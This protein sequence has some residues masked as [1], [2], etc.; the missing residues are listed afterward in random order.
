MNVKFVSFGVLLFFLSG[1]IFSAAGCIEK[2]LMEYPFESNGTITL[3]STYVVV[4][5]GQNVCY[6]NSDKISC[7]EPGEPFY[8]QDAQYYGTQPSYQDNDDGTITDLN[9]GLMWQ[10]TPTSSSFS[11]QDSVEYCD[12]LELAGY[13]DWRIPSAKELFSLSDFSH[14]WP[15]LDTS[16]FDIAGQDVSKDE[17]YWTSN[18]YVGKTHNGAASA[19]G[20][21]HGAGHIKAYPAE[22]SG[23]FGNYV[24]A[25]RGDSCDSNG[26]VDN[27]NGTIN[28]TATGLIWQ[29]EDSGVGMNWEDALSY[30]ENLELG[31]YDD[32]RLP[33]VK[34]LQSIVDYT[35]S[36]NA[37]D[38]SDLG[39]AIDTDFFEITELAAGTTNYDPDYGYFWTSTSAYFSG[40]S[41]EYYYAWYVAFGTA[42]GP[43]GEDTH[44]AGAVRFDTKVEGGPDAEGGERIYNYV[45]CVRGG[46]SDNQAPEKPQ[47][48]QG[49]ASGTSGTEYTYTTSTTDP[50]GEQLYFWFDWGD[51][52]S[53]GWLGPYESGEE[54]SASHTWESKGSYELKVKAK[55]VN[56]TQ[57]PWSD[58]L[59]ITMPKSDSIFS[60]VYS[61]IEERPLATMIAGGIGIVI[62][63]TILKVLK[64]VI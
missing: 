32:W 53:S 24:R 10:K 8:G 60:Q 20:V 22:A 62:L 35:H 25:V 26:F 56:G 34:E 23:P 9:T 64:G 54:V 18:F 14:G 21:N 13:D 7:P 19:F 1:S 36:S 61:F 15:Y 44:G 17:Q 48:P 47:T 6:D 49:N 16:Y 11:W 28:D 38:E 3:Q 4:D 57:S 37:E 31:G 2:D 5:T 30:A 27:E 50:E 39:P 59:P 29:Q 12:N 63:F 45:R 41:P 52:S 42:V 43:D 40:A 51:D 55:D 46:L 58:P 33:N